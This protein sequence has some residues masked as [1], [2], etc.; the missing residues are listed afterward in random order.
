M[1]AIIDTFK[2]E[3]RDLYPQLVA[4]RRNFHM[5]PEL[6]GKPDTREFGAQCL[7]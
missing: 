5:H 1:T 3:A 2:H 6:T 4:W 7:H